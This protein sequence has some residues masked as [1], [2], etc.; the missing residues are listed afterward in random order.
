MAEHGYVHCACRDCFE[1]AI[2]VPGEAVCLECYDACC[3]TCC[4]DRRADLHAN[5]CPNYGQSRA[6][7]TSI[8]NS[9]ELEELSCA[10]SD[11]SGSDDS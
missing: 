3:L 2:G 6:C 10:I 5:D 4:R 11:A 1:L 9:A 8:I 7:K